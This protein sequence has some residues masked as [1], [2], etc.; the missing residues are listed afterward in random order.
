MVLEA[1]TKEG[2]QISD[3]DACVTAA[4]SGDITALEALIAH[5]AR[6]IRAT[7]WRAGDFRSKD[8]VDDAMQ[9]ALEQ[10]TKKIGSF[11]RRAGICTWMCSVA[12]YR[13]LNLRRAE[14]RRPR[15][16][17]LSS[18]G[19]RD[20]VLP[21]RGLDESAAIE[22]LAQR[23]LN[24]LEPIYREVAVLK[25]I[26]D[27]SDD[28]IATALCINAGTVRSRLTTIRKRVHFIFGAGDSDD[29]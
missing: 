15:V 14:R 4:Q 11:G 20:V 24:A 18:D 3:V 9:E 25:Y 22:D 13:T 8:D 1:W 28:E 26:E 2:G 23:V 16:V 12:R 19:V 6:Q 5:C 29:T 21:G 10:I 17:S 27:L 7:V